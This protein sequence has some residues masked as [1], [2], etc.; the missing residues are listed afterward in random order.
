MGAPVV[1]AIESGHGANGTLDLL[2][3]MSNAEPSAFL[4]KCRVGGA[5]SGMYV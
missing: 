5:L 3:S 4:T 2:T 1:A